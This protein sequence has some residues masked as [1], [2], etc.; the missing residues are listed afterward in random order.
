MRKPCLTAGCPNLTA[1]GTRCLTCEQRRQHTRNATRTWYQGDWPKLRAQQLARQPW[2]SRC[3]AT[4]DLTVDHVNNRDDTEL[5]TLCRS[6]N[7]RKA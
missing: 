7:G 4:T 5:D 2:C 3:G 6:C 1:G